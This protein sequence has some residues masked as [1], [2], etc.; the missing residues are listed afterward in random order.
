MIT[1]QTWNSS[2][3]ESRR[4]VE[5]LELNDLSLQVF[6]WMPREQSF[7]EI[8]QKADIIPSSAAGQRYV[9]KGVNYPLQVDDVGGQ[10]CRPRNTRSSELGHDK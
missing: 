4:V 3:L 6:F 8:A 10:V 7:V 2:P 5:P 1:R 9:L